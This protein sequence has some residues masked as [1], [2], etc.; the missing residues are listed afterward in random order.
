MQ[1]QTLWLNDA[2]ASCKEVTST[3]FVLFILLLNYYN[4][5]HFAISSFFITVNSRA[6]V[7]SFNYKIYI[8]LISKDELDKNQWH[9]V[10]SRVGI[11]NPLLSFQLPLPC[12]RG[13][14]KLSTTHKN[15]NIG[16][17]ISLHIRSMW[18]TICD[19]RPSR[20]WQGKICATI[21]KNTLF[22]DLVQNLPSL[23]I[24]I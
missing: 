14:H 12:N 17:F 23:K 16:N 2:D 21:G 13:F 20:K 7:I 24:E 8:D 11:Q 18:E 10:K 5:Q 3:W 9:F 19:A 4:K 6:A 15:A 22:W 1:T